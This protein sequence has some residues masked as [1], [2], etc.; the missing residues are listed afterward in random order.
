[1]E[2][3]AG[4][5]FHLWLSATNRWTERAAFWSSSTPE[6]WW[7]WMRNFTPAEILYVAYLHICHVELPSDNR[8]A[9]ER[10]AAVLTNIVQLSRHAPDHWPRLWYDGGFAGVTALQILWMPRNTTGCCQNKFLA[11]VVVPALNRTIK[12]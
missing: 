5:I 12:I 4:K 10:D 11:N 7:Q 8:A 3:N 6:W 1:M 9:W 2:I